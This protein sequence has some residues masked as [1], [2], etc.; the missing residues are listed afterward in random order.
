M[1]EE[2]IIIKNAKLLEKCIDDNKK[3]VHVFV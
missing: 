3:D 2:L 1:F